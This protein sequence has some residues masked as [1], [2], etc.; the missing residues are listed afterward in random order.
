MA[1]TLELSKDGSGKRIKLDL[2]KPSR[3]L[4]ELYL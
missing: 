4:V 1:L 2:V 3:F